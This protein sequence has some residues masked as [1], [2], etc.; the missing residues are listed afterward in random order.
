MQNQKASPPSHPQQRPG[1]PLTRPPLNATPGD[2][3]QLN[4]S[5]SQLYT[6]P[7]AT[8]PPISTQ[9]SQMQS[10]RPIPTAAQTSRG[11]YA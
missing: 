2:N 7:M 9:G 5:L 4:K 10:G 11:L 3:P 6:P 1:A 8:R